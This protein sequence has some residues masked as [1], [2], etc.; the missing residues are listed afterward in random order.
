MISTIVFNV[1][2]I[3]R[4]VF[5]RAIIASAVVATTTS[6]CCGRR[7]IPFLGGIRRRSELFQM[8]RIIGKRFIHGGIVIR[9]GGG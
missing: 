5:V 6:R 1:I 8:I 3:Y 9:V 4:V 2:L 7:R